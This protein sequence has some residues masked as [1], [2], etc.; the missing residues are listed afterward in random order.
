M[1]AEA[2][3]SDYNGNNYMLPSIIVKTDK[4]GEF[5]YVVENKNGNSFAKKT[6]IKTGV[7]IGNKT[8]IESG[9]NDGDKVVI[10]G[11]SLIKNNSKVQIVK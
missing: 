11:Y 8:V 10:E 2:E 9:L 4:H 5:V 6:Y 3:L 7:V 1:I